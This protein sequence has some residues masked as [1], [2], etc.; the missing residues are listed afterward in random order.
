MTAPCIVVLCITALDDWMSDEATRERVGHELRA[1]REAAGL[2]GSAVARD[3][4][5]SQ[6]KVSRVETG[7]F[8]ASLGEVATLLSF[9]GVAEEVRAEILASVA[10][11]DGA[12]GTW[13][14]RAGGPARRQSEVGSIEE[15]VKKVSQYQALTIPGLL[16]AP[17]YALAIARSGRFPSP[18]AIVENRHE[19]QEAL[20]QSRSVAYR[21]VIEE[22][23]LWR[24]PGSVITM[25]NQLTAI[26]DAIDG[27]FVVLRIRPEKKTN[28]TFAAGSF[29]LYDFKSGPPVVLVEAQTSD[30]Y[31]SSAPDVTAYRRLF[32]ELQKDSLDEEASRRLIERTRRRLT[33]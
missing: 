22:S 23:V 15:R 20:A 33:S 8:G 29:V 11:H 27:K 26:L 7:R 6:S 3:L 1:I 19:R 14:V 28:A 31:L 30:L 25:R 2:S 24:S 21:A 10:R 18:T 9:Y 5:W 13:V 32:R 17:D 16:Q 12:E 4:G